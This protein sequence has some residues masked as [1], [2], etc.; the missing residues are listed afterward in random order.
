MEDDTLKLAWQDMKA[1]PKSYAELKSIVQEGKHPAL[2][3]I[4]KQLILETL[5]FS[6][7]L[8]V[9]YDF[10]DGDRKSLYA[11]VLIVTAVLLI[12]MHNI[13]GYILTRR[14]IKGD[15]LKQLLENHLL[16]IKVYALVSIASRVLAAIC[17]LIFFASVIIVN[18]ARYWLLAGVILIFI[19]QVALLSRIWIGRIRQ[20][21]ETVK[22]FYQ[23]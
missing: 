15:N 12:I 11:N 22:G 1:M 19:I 6:I 8:F 23:Q 2:K 10:F 3:R 21:K 17:L 9:Y 4:R 18:E 5:C 7:F 20:I 13:T 14:H 16:K